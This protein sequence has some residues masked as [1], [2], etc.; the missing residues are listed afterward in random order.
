MMN[1][2]SRSANSTNEN[3]T[4]AKMM[5]ASSTTWTTTNA[6]NFWMNLNYVLLAAYLLPPYCGWD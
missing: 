3:S 1:K 2:S 4:S 5:N 6:M